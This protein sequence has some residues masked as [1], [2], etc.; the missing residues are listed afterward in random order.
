MFPSLVVRFNKDIIPL[1]TI[2]YLCLL[3]P[4]SADTNLVFA[5]LIS[6]CVQESVCYLLSLRIGHILAVFFL[7]FLYYRKKQDMLDNLMRITVMWNSGET[8]Y[9]S[10][11]WV[12]NWQIWL[13]NQLEVWYT[14]KSNRTSSFNVIDWICNIWAVLLHLYIRLIS[15]PIIL[16][17]NP[18]STFFNE[19][20]CN[21]WSFNFVFFDIKCKF[22]FRPR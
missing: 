22:L 6:D 18:Y 12:N 1:F 16:H 7:I 14:N 21:S 20:I 15:N 10:F 8:I 4:V 3:C 9:N 11:P 2:I 13:A 5:Y 17:Y 19:N